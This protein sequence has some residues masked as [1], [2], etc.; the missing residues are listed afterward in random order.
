MYIRTDL[1]ITELLQLCKSFVVHAMSY[2]I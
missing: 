2:I 1:I